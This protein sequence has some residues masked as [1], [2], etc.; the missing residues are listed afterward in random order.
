M[1]WVETGIKAPSESFL[2]EARS[3]GKALIHLPVLFVEP[4]NPK[5]DISRCDAAFVGSPRAAQYALKYLKSF[6]FPVYT[7]GRGTAEA[8]RQHG[9]ESQY[10]SQNHE[11]ARFF[12]ESLSK[13]KGGA[14]PFQ[15]WAWF[16]AEE[17]FEDLS[18][19]ASEYKIEITHVPLYRT[20]PFAESLEKLKILTGPRCLFVRSGKAAKAIAS[21]VSKEDSVI[22]FGNSAKKTLESLGISYRDG[23]EI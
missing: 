14:I 3:S 10:F 21:C 19:L 4:L 7:V 9:I 16:S 12:L 2:E 18:L 1:W 22:A 11:G 13:I 15:R 6:P 17:T 20:F 8:L 5:V 23:L